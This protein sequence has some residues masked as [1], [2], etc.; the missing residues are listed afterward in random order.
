MAAADGRQPDR[1]QHK[2]QGEMDVAGQGEIHARERQAEA[3]PDD[4][5]ERQEEAGRSP[6][7]VVVKDSADMRLRKLVTLAFAGPGDD[8]VIILLEQQRRTLG[9]KSIEKRL[10][11]P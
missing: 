9:E 11:L 6:K 10:L 3:R 1:A 8:G 2:R 7:V 5:C 4:E